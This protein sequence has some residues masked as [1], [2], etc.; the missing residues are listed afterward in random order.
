MTS[1]KYDGVPLT[2]NEIKVQFENPDKVR[3]TPSFV[4][5]VFAGVYASKNFQEL[6]ESLQSGTALMD[7]LKFLLDFKIDRNP[8]KPLDIDLTLH[9]AEKSPVYADAGVTMATTSKLPTFNVNVLYRNLFGNAETLKGLASFGDSQTGSFS[10]L[11]SKPMVFDSGRPNTPPTGNF[12]ASISYNGGTIFRDSGYVERSAGVNLQLASDDECH[13]LEYLGVWRDTLPLDKESLSKGAKNG[14]SNSILTACRPTMKSSMRY[15]FT[16]DETD[17]KL[18]PTKGHFVK[19]SGEVAG[20]GGDVAFGK[21]EGSGRIYH[22]ITKDVSIGAG[23]FGGLLAPLGA[24]ISPKGLNPFGTPSVLNDR[25]FFRGVRDLR[26]RGVAEFGPHDDGD[27]IGGDAYF[28]VG[29]HVSYCPPI[30]VFQENN[31]RLH[32]FANAGNL[33][34]LSGDDKDGDM[35]S[36]FLELVQ[37]E[38]L[39]GSAGIGVVAPMPFGRFEINLVSPLDMGALASGSLRTDSRG[40][41]VSAQLRWA[42]DSEFS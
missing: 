34:L 27:A 8:K 24:L 23:C 6:R 14:N 15:T 19:C 22:P 39:R 12:N 29:S 20:F 26:I 31:V 18:I 25:F 40:N 35:K 4:R 33:Q 16:H 2:I 5:K 30:P 42:L 41:G 9:V 13:K 32:A 37:P 11:F 21:M 1:T 28:T 36:R 3:T 10:L 38:N 7:K 17:H